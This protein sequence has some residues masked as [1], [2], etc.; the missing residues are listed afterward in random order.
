MQPPPAADIITGA[1][2]WEAERILGHGLV[3]HGRKAVSEYLITVLGYRPERSMWQDDV[4]HCKWLVKEYWASK[5]ESERLVIMLFPCTCAHDMRSHACARHETCLVCFNPHML[6]SLHCAIWTMDS[7][8]QRSVLS[9]TQLESR[10]Q[11]SVHSCNARLLLLVCTVRNAVLQGC[12][13]LQVQ[14]H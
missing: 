4:D 5:P 13:T 10:L 6:H 11:R 14:L 7:L 9:F 3:K 2:E 12:I 1:P 8:M